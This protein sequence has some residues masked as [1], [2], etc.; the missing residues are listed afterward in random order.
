MGPATFCPLTVTGLLLSIGLLFAHDPMT[1]RVTWTG[2]INRLVRAR[3]TSCH[4]AGGRA[5]MPLTTYAEARPWARA[6]KEE[7]LTRRMPKWHAVRGYG[8]FAND[9]SLSP[10][11]IALVSAWVDG[12]APYGAESDKGNADAG[13]PEAATRSAGREVS[14]A[15]GSRAL[16]EGELLAI[17][18]TLASG[19]SIGV[20]IRMPDGRQEIVGWIRHFDPDFPTTY[21]LRTPF[22]L[23]RGSRLIADVEGGGS[24]CRVD[25]TVAR[26]GSRKAP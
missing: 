14:I 15:C 1:T 26:A 5:P 2:E 23:R 11:E 10:F 3:C 6:I 17:R 9:P 24:E 7:V 16:P 22:R 19:G 12:G 25:L 8:D 20:A 13:I 4:A 18:P 21:W